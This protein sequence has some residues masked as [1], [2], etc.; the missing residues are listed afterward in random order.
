METCSNPGLSIDIESNCTGFRRFSFSREDC[1][2]FTANMEYRIEFNRADCVFSKSEVRR[3]INGMASVRDKAF[4]SCLYDLQCW[5]GELLS[6]KIKDVR[7]T[8]CGDVQILVEAE[9]TK[10]RH[11]ETLSEYCSDFATAT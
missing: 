8:D 7:Y 5:V 3:L 1:Q 11:W 2:Y 10:L 4:F 6:R 9:K